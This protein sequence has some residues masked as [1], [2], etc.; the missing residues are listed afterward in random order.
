[1]NHET[2]HQGPSR[3]P[4]DGCQFAGRLRRLGTHVLGT[5]I[6]VIVIGAVGGVV[7]R[8]IVRGGRTM[9]TSHKVVLTIAGS[10]LGGLL[11]RVLLHH[12]RGF[13]QPSSWIGSIIGSII[14]VSIYLQVQQR[15]NLSLH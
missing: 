2:R 8:N 12:G 7:A 11:G 9:N 10:V 14:V 5:F 3:E 13:T 15:R 4:P 1:V 6:G